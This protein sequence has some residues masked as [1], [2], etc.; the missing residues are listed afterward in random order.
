MS[1][2]YAGSLVGGAPAVRRM[3]I[4]ETCYTG[5]LLM[6]SHAEDNCGGQCYILDIAAQASE[7]DHPVLG[8]CTGVYTINDAGWNSSYYGDTATYDSTQAAMVANDPVGATEIEMTV[9]LPNVTLIRGP[10]YNGTYGTAITELDVTSANAAGT[11]IAATGDTAIDY[12]DDYGVAYCRSGANRGHYRTLKTGDTTT[13]VA[14]IPFPKGIA[15]GDVFVTGPGVPGITG[16]Q[17]DGDANFLDASATLASNWYGVWLWEQN[18]EESGKEY[19]VF[20]FLPSSCG[21]VGFLG[22]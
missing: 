14:Q 16:L 15:V 20:A 18:L 6:G 3:Q 4:G 13:N 12:E 11:D 8:I 17:T 2:E 22:T 9:I 10:L 5:Q 1:F 19:Y 21:P 7:D